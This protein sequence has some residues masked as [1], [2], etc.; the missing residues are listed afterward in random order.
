MEQKEI[1]DA[2]KARNLTNEAIQK[3]KIK[4]LYRAMDEI[5]EAIKSKK[6]SCY[7]SGR[8]SDYVIQKLISLEYKTKFHKGVRGDTHNEDRYDISWE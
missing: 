2:D 7:I 4:E 1:I 6:F 3:G 5:H 8:T